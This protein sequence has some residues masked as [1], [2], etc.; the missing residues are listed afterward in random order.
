[1]WGIED[2]VKSIFHEGGWQE[3][4]RAHNAIGRAGL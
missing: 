2:L 3:F 1:M 4:I